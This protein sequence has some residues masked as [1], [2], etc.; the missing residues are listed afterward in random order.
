MSEELRRPLHRGTPGRS[1]LASLA[2]REIDGPQRPKGA[3]PCRT[4]DQASRTRSSTRRS[5]T[6][7]CRRSGQHASP[8]RRRLRV[9][10]ARSRVR[11]GTRD[12]VVRPHRRRLRVVRA[13]VPQR[14]RARDDAVERLEDHFRIARAVARRSFRL[15]R[16][17]RWQI[18]TSASSLT[19]NWRRRRPRER[20]PIAQPRTWPR[21]IEDPEV[22]RP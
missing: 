17:R 11:V 3:G 4:S 14:G 20:R 21:A 2:E 13:G 22:A 5:R 9:T 19:R 18:P 8:T 15:M 6:R 12:R 7:A 1:G 16:S 10:V